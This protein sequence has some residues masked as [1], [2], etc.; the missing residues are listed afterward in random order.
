ML[1]L[2]A[3]FVREKPRR[4]LAPPLREVQVLRLEMWQE[5]KEKHGWRELAEHAQMEAHAAAV[6]A[7]RAARREQQAH[8]EAAAEHERCEERLAEMERDF[9]KRLKEQKRLAAQV[10]R[11]PKYPQ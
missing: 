2:I 11:S 6:E 9:A 5:Y 1:G 4:T 3:D 8:A 10:A 7:Q